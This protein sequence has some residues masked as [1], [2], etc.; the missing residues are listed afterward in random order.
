MNR[1]PQAA[2]TRFPTA[3]GILLG[4]SAALQLASLIEVVF[5]TPVAGASWFLVGQFALSLALIR[6]YDGK[7]VFQDIRLFFVIFLFL[8][9]GTLPLVVISGIG[10]DAPGVA[11][12]AFMYG[13]AFLGFNLVQWWY[14]QPW[15]D[16]PLAVFD[17]IRP[18]FA[19]AMALMLALVFLG[20]YA[21]ALGVELS[22]TMDRSQVRFLGTQLWVV[23]MFVIN[24]FV[25]F[26]LAGWGRLTKPA[27]IAL[28]GSM[29]LFVGA[30]LAMGNRRDFLPM[31][32]FLAGVIA[33]RRHAVIRAGSVVMGGIAF[34]LFTAIGI[35]R[36]VLQDPTVL[37]RS[38]PLELI[39]QHNEFVSPIF[40]LMHYINVH[41]PLRWGFT[42]FSA[43]SL[44]FPRALWPDKPE[45]LSLQF[46]RDA[47]GTTGL[48]GFAYT[49]VTEAFLNF[50][51]VGP[52]I[53]FAIL[54]LL[55][56]KL[57]RNADAHPGLYFIA[58]AMTV[59]FNR[60]DFG[61]IF[62]AM[63]VVGGAYAIMSF[64]SRLRWAPRNVR[65]VWTPSPRPGGSDA[66]AL[67]HP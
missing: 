50:W 32:V 23:M 29:L 44:F 26:M 65:S 56:V 52:F 13:T 64:I 47:F 36:Q 16:I 4:V 43:P 19:N 38:N 17:R 27:R 9:G 39:V 51:W 62:Y 46:M 66:V 10:G 59:D 49:P 58:F 33:T 11:G 6:L 22:L 45:S 61:G 25:M 42:Y 34:A 57:V 24:G 18:S 40:T 35:L 14:R 37:V 2:A 1:G 48:M 21:L 67:P 28:I 12:A 55:M 54:S 5:G 53:V 7:W 15:R 8:Y 31:L 3:P 30:Q 60:G 20:V 63:V 41:R